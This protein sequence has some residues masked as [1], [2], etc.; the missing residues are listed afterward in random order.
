MN[1]ATRIGDPSAPLARR[2]PAAKVAAAAVLTLALVVSLDP[3]APAVALGA[4]LLVVPLFGVRYGAL[5]RRAWPLCASVL[6]AVLTLFLFAADREHV[7][8]SALALALRLFAVALPGVVVLATTDPTDL[9]DALVQ[10]ARV[11]ARFAIGTLA[12][13]RLVPL[14]AEEWRLINLAR[15]ARG[16]DPGRDP[17]ARLRL[18]VSAAFTLLVGAIRRGVGLAVAMDARGF[19][20]GAPR[21]SAR[22]QRFGAA[23]AALVAGAFALAALAVGLSVAVGAFRPLFA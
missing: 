5:A 18:F 11:P 14:M 15:R 2:N 13:W 12:A 1:R 17:V 9:A 16:V 19:A 7:L 8:A 21:T 6:G 23:D 10:N 22:V 20:S 3:V 4:E